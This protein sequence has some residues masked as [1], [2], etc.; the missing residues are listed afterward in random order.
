[1]LGETLIIKRDNHGGDRPNL[2]M[3]LLGNLFYSTIHF[4]T[5]SGETTV[6][7]TDRAKV[8]YRLRETMAEN[9][10]IYLTKLNRFL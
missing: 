3:V 5:G 2:E 4:V 8:G 6:C 1:M 7:M 9:V 10:Q